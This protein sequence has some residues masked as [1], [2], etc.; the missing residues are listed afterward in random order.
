MSID[1]ENYKSVKSYRR[2]NLFYKREF[3]ACI[4][5]YWVEDKVDT[6]FDDLEAMDYP[7][8]LKKEYLVDTFF[9]SQIVTLVDFINPIKITIKMA[10]NFCF[11]EILHEDIKYSESQNE[12]LFANFKPLNPKSFDWDKAELNNYQFIISIS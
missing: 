9:F 4:Y 1:F 7:L 2:K 8:E 3:L 12:K 5:E 11:Y 6:F 10:K